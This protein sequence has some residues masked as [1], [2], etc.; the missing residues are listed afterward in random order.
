MRKKLNPRR[1]ILLI[2]TPVFILALSL[3]IYSFFVIHE[4]VK[5]AC[6][7]AQDEY[8]ED[9]VTSLIKYIQSD[10]HTIR[11]RNSAIWALGQLAEKEALLF[12]Y[13]LNKTLPEQKKCSY[14]DYLCK[15]EVKKAIKWCEKDNVTSWMYRNRTNWH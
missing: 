2:A 1:I 10:N 6:L 14:D 3:F 12:L 7:K 8:Q 4:G 11:N 5:T 9:C 15:Y 13:E